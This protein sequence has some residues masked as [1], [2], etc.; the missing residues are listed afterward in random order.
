MSREANGHEELHDGRKDAD[1]EEPLQE[2]SLLKAV[3]LLLR[4]RRLVAGLPL[5]LAFLVGVLGVLSPREHEARSAFVPQT[6]DSRSR[7]TGL[8]AQFGFA[9]PS[10]A[11]AESPEFY[12]QLLGSR[13]LLSAAVLTEYR[14]AAGDDKQDTL[15]GNYIELLGIEADS[16]AATMRHAIESLR[17]SMSTEHNYESS[18]LAI[19]VRSPWPE[20]SVQLNRRLLSLV[21]EFNVERRQSQASAERSFVSARLAEAQA[22]LA[23]SEA[24]FERFLEQNRRYQDSPQLTFEF[25]R[26]QQR[27]D[28]RRQVYNSLAQAFEQ[29]RIEEVRNTPVISIID[30]PESGAVPV[31]RNTVKKAFLA[32]IIGFILAA[33]LAFAREHFRQ[34][35][36]DD[37]REVM[38]FLD[39]GR[40][41]LDDF[42]PQ[43]VIVRLRKLRPGEAGRLPTPAGSSEN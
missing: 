8:A 16:E 1:Y 27:V 20:L 40:Q 23:A 21:E 35:R 9:L 7:M 3:N 32:L 30:V 14:I 43:Q 24:E 37:D 22:E 6:V 34:R 10:G 42:R 17:G 29:A 28:L 4:N 11:A 41:T 5:G 31:A 36:A 15:K 26:L 12:R 33:L 39:L 2:I 25:G 13:D 19:R 38:T 18:I